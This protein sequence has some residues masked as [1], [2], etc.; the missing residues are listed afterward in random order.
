[1]NVFDFD[2]APFA[3]SSTI[4][5]SSRIHHAR[6]HSRPPATWAQFRTT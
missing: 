1:M 5:A 4:A 2:N 6:Y 3:T